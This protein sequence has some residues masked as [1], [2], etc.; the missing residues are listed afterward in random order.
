MDK[1]A[2]FENPVVGRTADRLVVS[3]NSVREKLQCLFRYVRDEI[4]FE[5]PPE[6]DFVKAS[7]TIQRGY[8]Q[9]NTKAALLLALCKACDIPAKIHFSLISKDIQKGFFTGLAYW[10]M[11]NEISHSWIEVKVDERWRRIDTFI[12]DRE[13]YQAAKE[14]LNRRGWQTGF[15]LALSNG[16]VSPDLNL[17]SEAF[18]QMAAVTSDHGTWDDPADYYAS[19]MYRNRPGLLRLWAYRVMIDS[20][21]SRVRKL[22]SSATAIPGNCATG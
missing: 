17:D 9:C 10:L 3:S 19:P 15:S 13:L 6:G 1:L 20:V 2:D 18:Q 12:N 21:N 5:F 4:T 7:D 11:P 22:R 8:G 16:D 14:E